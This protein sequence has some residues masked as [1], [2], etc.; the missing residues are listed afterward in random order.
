MEYNN[1]KEELLYK[2]KKID[3]ELTEKQVKQ[4]YNYMNLLIEWNNNINLTAIT[5]EKD[6]IL[7]HFVDSLTV[8]K[9]IKENKSIVDVGTG[10]GFPGIP[11]AIMNDSLKITLV[12]SL[13]K[14]INFLNEVCSKIKLKNTKAIHS[15]AEEFGQDNNYRESYDI[16]ISRAVSNLTVLA[17]Y[18]LPLVKVGGKIICMKGPDIEEEL[19]QAKSAIDILGGKFERCDNFCLPKSDISRNIIIINKI[20]ETPKKYPRKAGTP[21]KTPLFL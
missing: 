12:D 19:K 20:K 13:N 4:F 14:R 9:Y 6:I 3:I 5:E 10:A 16:A 17:E 8:L 1:F 11:L 18:L 21:V 7:K 2:M 15:R